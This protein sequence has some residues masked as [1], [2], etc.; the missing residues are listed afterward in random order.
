MPLF[1]P[2]VDKVKQYLD[3]LSSEAF[4]KL[5]A[6]PV[7]LRDHFYNDFLCRQPATASCF[8]N[9]YDIDNTLEEK[10]VWLAFFHQYPRWADAKHPRSHAQMIEAL[11]VPSREG[12]EELLYSSLPNPDHVAVLKRGLRHEYLKHE[13]EVKPILNCLSGYAK[14][15]YCFKF[16]AP[17]TTLIGPSMA[18][19]TCLITELS[20]CT[21]VVH[22][23]LQ[24]ANFTG[25]PPRSLLADDFLLAN[26]TALQLGVHYTRLLAATCEVVSEFFLSQ[27]VDNT[28]HEENQL[29]EWYNYSQEPGDHLAT[30][31]RDT[32]KQ[33]P[34]DL[35]GASASF[36]RTFQKLQT[37]TSFIRNPGLKVLF[38]FDDAK[39]LNQ[40]ETTCDQE[41]LYFACFVEY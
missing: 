19:K 9:K 14:E 30:R 15:W 29:V 31:V 36:T 1:A 6:V 5:S 26:Q 10:L 24:P 33:S 11:T 20:K 4:D 27:T 22:I 21:C 2:E 37:S 8:I 3:D 7:N 25:Q 12:E 41:S 34:D 39:T 38:A 17:C 16:M 13:N 18:G 23:C 40:L 35:R 28:N 32:M